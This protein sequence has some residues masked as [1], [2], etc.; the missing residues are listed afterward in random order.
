[1]RKA[2]AKPEKHPRNPKTASVNQGAKAFLLLY[3]TLVPHGAI[4]RLKF[5]SR[6]A[7]MMLLT[8]DSYE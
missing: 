4:P 8:G 7:D 1:M 3:A 5:S 6:S 2:S